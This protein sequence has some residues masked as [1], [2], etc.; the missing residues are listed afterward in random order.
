MKECL[1]LDNNEAVSSKWVEAGTLYV[2]ATPIGNLSDFTERAREV[3][4][5][6]DFVA[7]EDTRVSGK[8]M[9]LFGIKKG[10]VNYFEHN[11]KEMGSRIVERLKSGESCAIVT[12]AGTPAISDPGEELVRLCHENG[13]KVVPVPGACAAISALC[14]SGMNSV[15]FSFEGFLPRDNKE[16]SQRLEECAQ[17]KHTMIFYEA[18]HR[19]VKTLTDMLDAFGDRELFVAREIT[20]IN[21]ELFLTTISGALE[22]FSQ[23]EPRG[24]LVLVVGGASNQE[25]DCFWSEMSIG[26]HVEFYVEKGLSQ[27][28]AIKLCAKDRHVAKNEIYK[29]VMKK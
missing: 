5:G 9:S 24:E 25:S 28:D 7:A 21:E 12:D 29:A 1:I 3:L 20:K 15:R 23:K 14:A 18:P 22:V 10:T 26:R 2:V 6:V 16:R 19:I 13:V 4:A 27:M 11:K 17:D 8:L